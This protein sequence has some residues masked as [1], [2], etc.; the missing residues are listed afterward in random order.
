MQ[1]STFSALFGALSNESRMSTIANNLAN[2]NTTAYKKDRLAFHDTFVRFAHDYVV[3]SK[4]YLRDKDMFPKADIMARARLSD[5]QIDFSQGSLQKTGNKLDFALSGQGF[6]SVQTPEGPLYTRAGNFVTD[7]VGTLMT[8]RGDTVL[9]DGG[10]LSI[11]AGSRVTVD[12]G[13]MISV[14]GDPVGQFDLVA[15]DD[16]ELMEKVGSTYYRPR[17]GQ[18]PAEPQ[19]LEVQQGFLERGNVEV[20]TEMVS[21]IETQRAFQTYTKMIQGTDAIDKK[22]INQVGMP[23]G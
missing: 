11:P 22:L 23:R 20:V 9:V 10:P 4:P 19:D 17:D 12:P 21:M 18:A 7:A 16:P 6:F 3:D 14:N 8:P 13:G 5:Q 2:V 1:D 15:F